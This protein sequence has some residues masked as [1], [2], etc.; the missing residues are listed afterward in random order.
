MFGTFLE[1]FLKQ[2]SAKYKIGCLVAT[3]NKQR[4]DSEN[5]L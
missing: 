3:V 1:K 4:Y 2:N 5:V